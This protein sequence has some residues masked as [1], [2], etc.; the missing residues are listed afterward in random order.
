MRSSGD[1]VVAKPSGYQLKDQPPCGP[2]RPQVLCSLQSIRPPNVRRSS[3]HHRFMNLRL[4]FLQKTARSL[5]S[6]PVEPLT[7]VS[8]LA[9][10][11]AHRSQSRFSYPQIR[12]HV[13]S[14]YMSM[15]PTASASKDRS[16]PSL[17]ISWPAES[18]SPTAMFAAAARTD[19]RGINKRQVRVGTSQSRIF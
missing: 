9:A 7:A 19:P 14:S 18:Q 4:C 1:T 16:I 3:F 11:T 2:H 15:A 12:D 13:L 10:M 6:R 17:T 8:Q 5:L